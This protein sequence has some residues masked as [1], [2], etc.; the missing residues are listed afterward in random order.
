MLGPS[1]TSCDT[2]LL[3]NDPLSVC[4]QADPALSQVHFHM[5]TSMLPRFLHTVRG[6]VKI[7]CKSSK[8]QKAPSA[9]YVTRQNIKLTIG[10][11]VLSTGVAA[12]VIEAQG[13]REA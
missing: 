13:K 1:S 8:H 10:C 6:G 2:A 4:E 3:A 7:L 5:I 11:G 9:L 12:P